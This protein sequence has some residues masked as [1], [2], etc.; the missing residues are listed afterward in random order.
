MWMVAATL[1]VLG[2]LAGCGGSAA[3]PEA[4]MAM[5]DL[6]S[7][8]WPSDVL[9]GSDGRLAVAAPFPFTAMDAS[10]ALLA[11][12]LSELDGFG[13]TT[14]VFFPVS[15]PVEVDAGAT[16]TVVDLDGS[17]A[18][19]AYPLLYRAATRQ[20]VAMSPP[21]TVLSEHH[22]YG[23]VVG[24]GV[25]DGGGQPLRPSK[26]M[27]ELLAGGPTAPMAYQLLAV[28]LDTPPL[29]ATA[30]T[31]RTVSA[32]AAKVRADLAAVPPVAQPTRTFQPGPDLDD[33][34][35]GPVTTTL[36][37]RPPSGGV[38][39][40]HVAMVVEGT[41]ASPNYLAAADAQFGLFDD[42]PT[43]RSTEAIP[44]ML[45]L[46][47]LPAPAPAALPV[48]I[49]QHGIDGDRSTMLLVA[50]DY[51]ARGY[52]VL[53][54][55]ALWH[56]SRQPGAVDLV[57]NL[58]GAAVPDGIGDPNGLPVANFFD[59]TGDPSAGVAA[60]DP[61]I[62][63]DN[64][65]QATVDLLQTVQL[66]MAGDWSAVPGAAFDGAP[67]IYTAASFGAI[68]GA[69]VLA[70]DPTVSAGVLASGGGGL[71]TDMFGNSADLSP[72][73]VSLIGGAYDQAITVDHP[74]TDPVRAQMSLNLIQTVIEPGDGLALAG[75]A[76]PGTSVFFLEAFNDEVVPNHA[77]EALAAAWGASQVTLAGSPPTRVVALP[78]A[79][80]PF[81][82]NPLRALVQL[83][84]ACHTTF[85]DQQ[86]TR[87]YEDGSPPFVMRSPPLVVD[88][89]IQTAH[90]LALDF[91]DSFRHGAPTVGTADAHGH[92]TS[93]RSRPR[94]A[95]RAKCHSG[96]PC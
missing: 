35:G 63:R 84:P 94:S 50:D 23:C 19:R 92:E 79:P 43:M 72:L 29:A 16:A 77:T 8:P 89:P 6:R 52:A 61:R 11:Q 2:C 54:I 36:P 80:P 93:R 18:P 4:L 26:A 24:G 65:R 27:A 28:K 1:A 73:V 40:D 64:L 62:M 53:G 15:A 75:S 88:N 85:T 22:H 91:M 5:G 46:P 45:I 30:F 82:A 78:D 37:G 38:L 32:W 69:D 90:Q 9:L 87:A 49:F 44:F 58:S 59:F 3:P 67:P 34:F 68:L 17:E 83:D 10:L 31:T 66:A 57:N 60:L 25:H 70:L 96:A 7:I 76:P 33:L 95:V 21:G 55:D 47:A 51:A 81:A 74:D 56:G 13:T 48:A 86:D 71:F 41:F 20:L 42:G 14:A 39:H 12:A